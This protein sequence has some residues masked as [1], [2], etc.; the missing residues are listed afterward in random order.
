MESWR[1]GGGNFPGACCLSEENALLRAQLDYYQYQQHLFQCCWDEAER[2][3]KYL[4]AKLK[5]V[6]RKHQQSTSGAEAA[7]MDLRDQLEQAHNKIMT[8]LEETQ[9]L[10][11][12]LNEAL[13]GEQNAIKRQLYTEGM[14]ACLVLRLDDAT[15]KLQ[16]Y[17]RNF[18]EEDS[19]GNQFIYAELRLQEDQEVLGQQAVKNKV[20]PD[21]PHGERR[22]L[23][24]R[25]GTDELKAPEEEGN[26]DGGQGTY[27]YA[28]AEPLRAYEASPAAEVTVQ[29]R[30]AEAQGRDV[31]GTWTGEA[32]SQKEKDKKRG[33]ME[34]LLRLVK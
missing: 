10:R 3:S 25:Q 18:T 1:S 21:I 9:K 7:I 15:Q 13:M 30:E 4:K 22:A 11:V 34:W 23:R 31:M 8:Q 29:H 26:D 6:R 16:Q 2:E 33:I 28:L 5:G 32:E 12:K 24:V 27:A 14:M 17:N 20:D 19:R